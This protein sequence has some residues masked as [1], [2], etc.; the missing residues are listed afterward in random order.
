M[1]HYVHKANV[2]TVQEAGENGF[3]ECALGKIPC[4]KD[5][6]IV[7]GYDEVQYAMTQE[8]LDEDYVEIEVKHKQ[9]KKR[10]INYE[11]MAKAY[12]ELS[13]LNQ[14]EDQTYLEGTYKIANNK[15]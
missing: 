7:Q 14:E 2:V 4:N 3:I 12:E 13:L 11:D 15:A 1:K 9:K 10:K 5:D 8:Q 6:L